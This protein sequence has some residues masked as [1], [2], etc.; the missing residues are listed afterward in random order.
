MQSCALV[1][2]R[3]QKRQSDKKR[4]S[5]RGG[6]IAQIGIFAFNFDNCVVLGFHSFSPFHSSLFCCLYFSIFPPLLQVFAPVF[7]GKIKKCQKNEKI[8]NFFQKT[9]FLFNFFIV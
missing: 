5:R 2:A 9:P 4:R 6:I 8:S 7:E 3:G 1:H